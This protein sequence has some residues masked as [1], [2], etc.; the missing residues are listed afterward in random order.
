MKNSNNSSKVTTDGMKMNSFKEVRMKEKITQ[1]GKIRISASISLIWDYNRRTVNDYN[2]LFLSFFI[3]IIC[4]LIAISLSKIDWVLHTQ[5][6]RKW[7][8]LFDG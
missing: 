4:I 7:I 5:L 2:L 3:F 6:I 1:R 8:I